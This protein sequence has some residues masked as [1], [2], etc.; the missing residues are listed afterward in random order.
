MVEV[1]RHV[2]IS[3]PTLLSKFPELYK[4][5]S[6]RFA[7]YRREKDALNREGA[8]AEIKNICEQALREGIYPGDALVRSQ[9]TVPCQSHALSKMR[10]E[11]LV[12][13]GFLE[14]L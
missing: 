7:V 1:S 5:I 9:L 13:L 10:R 11:A 14:H 2:G 8:R 3:R 4:A 6:N 12:E